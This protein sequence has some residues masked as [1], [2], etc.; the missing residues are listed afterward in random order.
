MPVIEATTDSGRYRSRGRP[1][2][3]TRGR[4]DAGHKAIQA[5]PAKTSALAAKDFS[6][7]EGIAGRVADFRPDA[8]LYAQGDPADAVLYIQRGSVKLSLTSQAG[9][10][11][12]VGVLGDGDFCGEGALAPQSVRMTT[13]TTIAPSH[14]RFI[15]KREMSRL[16]HEHPVLAERFTAYLL[17]RIAR[18]EDDLV[19]QLFNASEKRLARTLLRLAGYG[20]NA[21]GSRHT[22]RPMPQEVLAEMVGT[23]R[24]RVNLFMNRFRER[25]FIDY[26]TKALTVHASLRDVVSREAPALSRRA[27][28]T[29][30]PPVNR[31]SDPPPGKR[32]RHALLERE[33]RHR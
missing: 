33:V 2:R 11:A 4:A 6:S 18:L 12:V 14:I 27:F 28:G 20:K 25:G 10:E 15:P 7:L 23:T 17:A 21:H 29:S 9:K 32:P 13:A 26:D 3:A 30:A 1:W 16:L 19:D 31:Y 22:L 5:A 24:S 8:T